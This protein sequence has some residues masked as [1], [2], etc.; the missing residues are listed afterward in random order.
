MYRTAL[1]AGLLLATAL[2]L[3]ANAASAAARTAQQQRMADCS[4][5]NK[6]LKEDAFKQ[7]QRS[8]L[9]THGAPVTTAAPATAAATPAMAAHTATAAVTPQQ[10]MAS[11][12]T[13]ASSRHLSGD[14]RKTF[15]S[16]CLRSH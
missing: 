10:R 13:D 6:G 16:G 4:A 3:A 15:M 2:P 5:K 12:N 1:L 7:A 11:C 9:I 8:C 14:A